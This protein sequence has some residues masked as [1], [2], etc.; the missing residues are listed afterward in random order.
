MMR[1]SICAFAVAAALAA[2]SFA[3]APQ[4]CT[5][6]IVSDL[7]VQMTDSGLLTV[8]VT[9]ND[10][11]FRMLVD[12][13]DYYSVV[14]SR[15]AK[16]LGKEPEPTADLILIGWGGSRMYRF[17]NLDEFGFGRMKRAKTQFMVMQS[18][19]QEFDGLIGADFFYYF[20]LD[21]DMAH[22]KLNLVSPERCKGKAVYWTKGDYAAIPF[23]YKDRK[24]VLTVTVDGKEVKAILD[25]GASDTVMS[26]DKAADMF[27]WNDK[28]TAEATQHH[29]FKSMSFGG[30]SVLNPA[31]E[32]ISDKRSVLLGEGG[33]RMILG[34]GVM[35][36]LHFL[37]SYK[38][39]MIYV[40]PAEQY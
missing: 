16:V 29:A 3:E 10:Q 35:R 12:T 15:T 1:A 7:D 28:T 2:S 34:M 24:I 27:D 17:V 37:I 9:L 31:I 6:R 30:I 23:D 8:P 33:P 20:D 21:F 19:G 38:E 13:G 14:T 18:T 36:R 11:P 5:L 39:E 4:N 40:T 32:L 26:L 25:T 22:A